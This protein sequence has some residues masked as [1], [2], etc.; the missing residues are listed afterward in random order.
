MRHN[1][2]QVCV[3]KKWVDNM[4]GDIF[5]HVC[6]NFHINWLTLKILWNIVRDFYYGN[7]VEWKVVRIGWNF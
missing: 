7:R 5:V 6:R 4:I 2:W 3:G 1:T